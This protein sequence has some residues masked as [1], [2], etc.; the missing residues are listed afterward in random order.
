MSGAYD[1]SSS[2]SGLR[3]SFRYQRIHQVLARSGENVSDGLLRL[4]MRC[5]SCPGRSPKRR[6]HRPYGDDE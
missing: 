2:S 6:R 1:C 4:L 3:E 5:A